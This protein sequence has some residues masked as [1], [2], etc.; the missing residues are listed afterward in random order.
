MKTYIDFFLTEVTGWESLD[1]LS[2][3]GYFDDI[4]YHSY[5]GN[6]RVDNPQTRNDVWN[7]PEW[8]H[9]PDRRQT[10]LPLTLDESDFASAV[11]D[12]KIQILSYTP[13]LLCSTYF[14]LLV[15]NKTF[16]ENPRGAERSII[17]TFRI[18]SRSSFV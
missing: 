12:V 17:Y 11:T 4:G 10:L 5:M 15:L 18:C 1:Y 9:H 14:S 6:P 7:Y 2:Y 3:R 16:D 8:R 13:E